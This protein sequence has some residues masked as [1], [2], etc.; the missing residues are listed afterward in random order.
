MFHELVRIRSKHLLFISS[1]TQNSRF[2][3]L[4]VETSLKYSF[5]FSFLIFVTKNY[6]LKFKYRDSFLVAEFLK[7][8]RVL[9]LHFIVKHTFEKKDQEASSL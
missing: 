6:Y 1:V 9:I 7:F 8:T 4:S 5:L 2:R 3:A